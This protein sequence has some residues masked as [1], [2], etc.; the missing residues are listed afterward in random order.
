MQR[1]YGHELGCCGIFIGSA[2][3]CDRKIEQSLHR[4]M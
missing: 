4:K 2:R 3:K 1:L